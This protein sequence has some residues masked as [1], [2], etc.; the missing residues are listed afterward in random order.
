MKK[1]IYEVYK[2]VLDIEY[3]ICYVAGRSDAIKIAE[4]VNELNGSD[5]F[6]R[7]LEVYESADEYLKQEFV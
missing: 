5:T 2:K 1:G 6:I 3:T 4:K 7:S